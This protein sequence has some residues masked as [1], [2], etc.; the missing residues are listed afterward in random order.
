MRSPVKAVVNIERDSVTTRATGWGTQDAVVTRD[1]LVFCFS[2]RRKMVERPCSNC[3]EVY[4]PSQLKRCARFL[5]FISREC[6]HAHWKTGHKE[7]CV[8]LSK[9]DSSN[10]AAFERAQEAIDKQ[11]GRWI[12]TW[13]LVLWTF[14]LLCFDL[15]NQVDNY[16]LTHIPVISLTPRSN[17]SNPAQ[18][19]KIKS[20]EVWTHERCESTYPELSFTPVEEL[21]PNRARMIITMDDDT[22]E[23]VMR[24]TWLITCRLS[25]IETYREIPEDYSR[26]IASCWVDVLSSIFDK[27]NV[28]EANRV[29][30]ICETPDLHRAILY[31]LMARRMV[32]RII[33]SLG[34]S[35]VLSPST[36]SW[37]N[38][39]FHTITRIVVP[40][41]TGS[42]P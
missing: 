35:S 10:P 2:T 34:I 14:G 11:L 22:E 21:E 8:P 15:P 37:T 3:G 42:D 1:K 20:G 31:E 17:M 5:I 33:P 12:S 6:Q 25:R 18:S 13:N 27:G 28:E 9:V 19:Y 23:G 7:S 38:P 41:P 32:Q 16:H 40:S 30:S 36:V 4:P 29:W 26:G 39:A 24:R